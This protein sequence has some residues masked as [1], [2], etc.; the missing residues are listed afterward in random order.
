MTAPATTD[1]FRAWMIER[2]AH[3]AAANDP[4]ATEAQSLASTDDLV[5]CEN[6]LLETPAA[7]ITGNYFR[8]LAAV[9]LSADGH[10]MDDDLAR[11][12]EAEADAFL[13]KQRA[14][15]A[16]FDGALAEYRRL[17]AIGDAADGMPNEDDLVRQWSEAMD[18]VIEN[19][20]APSV[21]AL[22]IK[23]DLIHEQM[24]GFCDWPDA[25]RNA[26]A[27][28]LDYLEGMAIAS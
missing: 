26:V 10:E 9:K 8:C 1:Q 2:G 27:K 28:D 4:G 13:A 11:V 12:I 6:R 17:R 25:Y 19:A 15:Q 21:A 3:Y 5:T 16:A 7:S 22:R 23:L 24:E 14:Q 20:L 18:H